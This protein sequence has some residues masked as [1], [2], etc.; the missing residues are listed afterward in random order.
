M[1]VCYKKKEIIKF[2]TITNKIMIKKQI[3]VCRLICQ[4]SGFVH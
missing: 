4:M 2:N 3:K 1:K